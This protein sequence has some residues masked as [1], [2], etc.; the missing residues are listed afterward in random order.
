M[1]GFGLVAHRYLKWTE[2]CLIGRNVR[3]V[4][5]GTGQPVVKLSVRRKSRLG[6]ELSTE[7]VNNCLWADTAKGRPRWAV[8]VRDDK[9][10]SI[11]C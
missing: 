2:N 1:A 7:A 3:M 9:R 10:M 5:G 4:E 11:H 6:L 8:L